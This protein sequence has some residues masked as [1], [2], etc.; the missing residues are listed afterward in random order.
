M[1]LNNIQMTKLIQIS[2][3]IIPDKTLGYVVKSMNNHRHSDYQTCT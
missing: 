1:R 3:E 2:K